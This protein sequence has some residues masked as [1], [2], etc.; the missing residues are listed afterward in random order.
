MAQG[1]SHREPRVEIAY[2]P[3]LHETILA[4]PDAFDGIE[5]ALDA[6]LDE[7]RRGLLDPDLARLGAVASGRPVTWRGRA[8]GLGCTAPPDAAAITAA[9]ARFGA[10]LGATTLSEAVR[11]AGAG[12]PR[13]AGLSLDA[14]GVGEAEAA[15]RRAEALRALLPC[16]LLLEFPLDRLCAAAPV[17]AEAIL[18]AVCD[19]T[20]CGIAL[21]VGPSLTGLD[22]VLRT[23]E[24]LPPGRVRRVAL[25]TAAAAAWP[26]LDAILSAT[27]ARTVVIR[28]QRHL[29]PLGDILDA[30]ARA[31]DTLGTGWTGPR[32]PAASGTGDERGAACS[33]ALPLDVGDGDVGG[34]A[35]TEGRAVWHA[36]LGDMHRAKQ[37]A[38]WAARPAS[39]GT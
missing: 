12:I 18:R 13:G 29:F 17:A 26:A 16:T 4:R 27:G 6:Y 34:E 9:L 30:A 14:A 19:A 36:R 39:W 33:Q 25:S 21:D 24:A 11:I 32:H 38:R 20:E 8:L 28:R 22:P 15:G 3:F 31:R 23:L 5:V 37:L 1:R 7:A 2:H 35:P 10:V